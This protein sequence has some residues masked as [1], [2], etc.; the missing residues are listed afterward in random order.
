MT[1]EGQRQLKVLDF[2]VEWYNLEHIPLIQLH[3]LTNRSPPL[4]SQPVPKCRLTASPGGSQGVLTFRVYALVG[5]DEYVDPAQ[6]PRWGALRCGRILS[7]PTGGVQN[8]FWEVSR[9]IS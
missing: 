6:A 8:G 3:F 2:S 5:V 9:E 1:D 7:A 4:I